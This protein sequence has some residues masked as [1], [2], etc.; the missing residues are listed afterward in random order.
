MP[1]LCR[2]LKINCMVRVLH[3]EDNHLSGILVRNLGMYIDL[4]SDGILAT[5]V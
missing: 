3:L 4:A 1:L 5:W 2:V